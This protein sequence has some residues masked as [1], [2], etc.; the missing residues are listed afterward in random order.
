MKK[1][2]VKKGLVV[3]IIVLFVGTSVVPSICGNIAEVENDHLDYKIKKSSKSTLADEYCENTFCFIQG[4]ATHVGFS[5]SPDQKYCIMDTIMFWGSW[6][7]PSYGS[8]FT[9][10]MNGIQ[11]VEGSFCGSIDYL[12]GIYLGV[13]GFIGIKQKLSEEPDNNG[14]YTYSFTGF[15]FR[16]K[17]LEM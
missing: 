3:G 16:V 13:F 17:L 2:I 11:T 9:I 10:G 15:A 12:P 7:E 8:V 6:P 5:S 4:E 1:S 14:H